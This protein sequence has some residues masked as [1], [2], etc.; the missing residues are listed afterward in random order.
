MVS[1]RF[2]ANSPIGKELLSYLS[3]SYGLQQLTD[4]AVSRHEIGPLAS[5]GITHP[6]F[7]KSTRKVWGSFEPPC[8][9]VF[10]AEV[11]RSRDNPGL[12]MA[13]VWVQQPGELVDDVVCI[14]NHLEWVR[15]G[16]TTFKDYELVYLSAY[17]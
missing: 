17:L 4:V 13:A 8:N 15:G 2:I 10:R 3:E 16:S 7:D 1:I 9:D 14:T 5:A 12:Y 6:R 11:Q